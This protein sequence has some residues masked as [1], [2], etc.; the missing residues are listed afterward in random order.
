MVQ[1]ALSS[2]SITRLSTAPHTRAHEPR[3]GTDA[4]LSRP[5][6]T[7]LVSNI[8]RHI[9]EVVSI[10]VE[11]G[12]LLNRLAQTMRQG[13][14]LANNVAQGIERVKLTA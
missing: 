11:N 10:L 4:S 9:K 5:T 1:G 6:C 3:L 2:N 12:I 7:S 8:R 13:G 14:R